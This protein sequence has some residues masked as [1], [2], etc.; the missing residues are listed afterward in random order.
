[1][2]IS[3]P[4]LPPATVAR[5]P[6][7]RYFGGRGEEP[8]LVPLGE[9]RLGRIGLHPLSPSPSG[10]RLP[11]PAPEAVKIPHKD[12]GSVA[13]RPRVVEPGSPVRVLHQAQRLE[14]VGRTGLEGRAGSQALHEVVDDAVEARL[15]A[16]VGVVA[17][18]PGARPEEV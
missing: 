17:L 9:A 18:A 13:G 6:E 15:V 10:G 5:D 16:P 14:V 8:S 11:Y 2:L 12:G 7:A 3:S 4:R 1:M